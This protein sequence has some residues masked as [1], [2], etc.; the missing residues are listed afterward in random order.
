LPPLE[1]TRSGVDDARRTSPRASPANVVELNGPS[2]G[3]SRGQVWAGAYSGESNLV[4]VYVARLR[5]KLA[6]AGMDNRIATIRDGDYRF[7]SK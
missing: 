7:R 6:A 1:S 2:D 3:L 4:D 5:W